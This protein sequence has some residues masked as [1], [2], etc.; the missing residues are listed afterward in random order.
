MQSPFPKGSQRLFPH[1]KNLPIKTCGSVCGVIA[2]I[3]G[4]I[5]SVAPSLWR[6]VFLST[7]AEMP[8]D[9]KSLLSQSIYSDFLRCSLVSWLLNGKVDVKTIR[10]HHTP[11]TATEHL[12]EASLSN[13]TQPDSPS[14][15]RRMRAKLRR[16]QRKQQTPISRAERLD[17]YGCREPSNQNR[18]QQMKFD[19]SDYIYVEDDCASPKRVDNHPKSSRYFVVI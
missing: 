11:R 19:D 4:G 9:L 2:A 10:I 3:L 15:R 13:D 16:R 1:L 18:P 7:T 12:P 6:H 5:A 17:A 14:K 8:E